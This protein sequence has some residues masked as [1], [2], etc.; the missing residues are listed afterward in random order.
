MQSI[1]NIP[2]R[3]PLL[4]KA[5]LVLGLVVPQFILYGPSL[6]GQKILLPLDILKSGG[7]YLPPDELRTFHSA[8]GQASLKNP[9]RSHNDSQSDQ[10][11]SYEI[12]RQFVAK[13]FR[14]GRIPLWTPYHYAGAPFVNWPKYSPFTLIYSLIPSPYVLAWIQ[15]IKTLVAGIGAFMFFRRCL[16]LGFWPATIIAWCLPLTGHFALWQGYPQTLVT[17]WLPWVLLATD[18]AVRHPKSLA[19]PVLAVMTAVVSVSGQFD[20][21]GHVLLA[22]GFFAVHRLIC[23]HKRHASPKRTLMTIAVLFGGWGT[24]F[25]LSG[26]ELL[27]LAEYSISGSRLSDTEEVFTDRPPVGIRSIPLLVLPRIYGSTQK[28]WYHL[29][30]RG[31]FES[32]SAAYTGLL[33]TLLLAPIAWCSRPHRSINILLLL[34]GLFALSWELNIPGLVHIFRLPFFNLRPHNRFVCV[35]SFAILSLA[36]IGLEVVWNHGLKRSFWF[37]LP[38]FLLLLTGGACVYLAVHLPEPMATAYAKQLQAGL[39]Q[40]DVPNM[41]AVRES[42]LI[43]R[44]YMIVN[45]TLCLV[46]LFAAIAVWIRPR[47]Q[48]RICIVLIP[49]FCGELIWFGYG[50]NAQSDPSL[51]YPKIPILERLATLPPGRVLGLGCLPPKLNEIHGLYEVRGYDGIDPHRFVKLLD[52]CRSVHSSSPDYAK[53]LNFLPR[54]SLSPDGE[55]QLPPIMDML[56]VRY[57]IFVPPVPVELTPMPE[58][59]DSADELGY[60]VVESQKALPRVYIPRTVASFQKPLQ[61]L[62]RVAGP[63]FNPRQIAYV[64]QKVTVPEECLGVAKIV[65]ETPMEVTVSIDMDTRGLLVLADRWDRGWRAW[66][67]DRELPILRTNYVLRG[68]VV[69]PEDETIVFRYEPQSFVW[70]VRLM[71]SAMTILMCW[72]IVNIKAARRG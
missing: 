53:T 21:A 43:Y 17:V 58:L 4:G 13:E 19:G 38:V 41:A 67:G 71:I 52:R 6:I 72:T 28:G 20:T 18:R 68:V 39:I 32:A 1:A 22:S 64:E 51:Y 59:K 45:A 36:A 37:V 35:A 69:E 24:G 54:M 44:T 7:H 14:A 2:S 12:E 29:A 62:A 9:F 42:R 8:D 65:S 27:P 34:L 66:S 33:L 56:A 31:E 10:I 60:V 70:G 48:K 11:L 57:L 26:P 25:L 30:G 63:E 61:I 3:Q 40:R 16:C 5:I 23:E 55:L 50:I 15:L 49:I 46:G 47:L